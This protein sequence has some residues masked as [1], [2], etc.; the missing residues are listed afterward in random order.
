[1]PPKDRKNCIIFIVLKYLQCLNPAIKTCLL[2]MRFAI[3]RKMTVI[4][5]RAD[6]GNVNRR[7]GRQIL[8]GRRPFKSNGHQIN[9]RTF[10]CDKNN[11][12][13]NLNSD[14]IS[15][16]GLGKIQLY[17]LTVECAEI[18]FYIFPWGGWRE[19]CPFNYANL[20]SWFSI[21]NGDLNSYCILSK[22]SLV[23]MS[24]KA[25]VA[26]TGCTSNWCCLKANLLPFT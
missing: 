25:V 14:E 23:R 22:Y 16:V 12:S 18:A 4:F 15:Q 13:Q 21:Y 26:L 7:W 9:K 1:M 5:R 11:G 17:G 2:G 20:I 24:V 3:G 19:E 10:N 6:G 8:F